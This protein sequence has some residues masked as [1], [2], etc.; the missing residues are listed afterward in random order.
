MP[1]KVSAITYPGVHFGRICR[2]AAVERGNVK[3]AQTPA[4][5]GSE[6]MFNLTP[7]SASCC[8]RPYVQASAGCSRFLRDR[9]WARERPML[10]RPGLGLAPPHGRTAGLRPIGRSVR[11]GT[12]FNRSSTRAKWHGIRIAEPGRAVVKA[13]FGGPIV[14]AEQGVIPNHHAAQFAAA[15][16]MAHGRDRRRRLWRRSAA[17]RRPLFPNTSRAHFPN[18]PGRCAA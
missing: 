4:C 14:R 10:D 9:A 13:G 7:D 5:R 15:R 16:N 2:L 1:D 11:T 6:L 17:A 8:G 3:F 12:R 18:P